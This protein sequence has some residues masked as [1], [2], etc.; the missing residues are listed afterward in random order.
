LNPSKGQF[1]KVAREHLKAVF[2]VWAFFNQSQIN[3]ILDPTTGTLNLSAF[4]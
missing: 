2:Q 3:M 4:N 1:H